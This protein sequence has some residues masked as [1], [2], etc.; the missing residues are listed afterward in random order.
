MYQLFHCNS[1]KQH[2]TTETQKVTWPNPVP[3]DSWTTQTSR[4]KIATIYIIKDSYD[5]AFVS[6]SPPKG[7][8]AYTLNSSLNYNMV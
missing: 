7:T 8:N 4:K 3:V 6:I 5:S 1:E 2:T